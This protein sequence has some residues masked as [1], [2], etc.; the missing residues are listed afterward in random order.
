MAITITQDINNSI[1]NAY[2]NAVILFE[3]DNVLPSVSATVDV[4]GVVL[5]ITPD[6]NG[7]FR[8]NFKEVIKNLI[9]SNN[10]SDA[11]SP[12]IQSGD[13]TTIKYDGNA[14]T[15]L[16][17]NVT[18]IV[19][20]SDNSTETLSKSY[21]FIRAV[22]QH[23]DFY[24]GVIE[25]NKDISLLHPIVDEQ[26]IKHYAR[27]F[28]GYPFDL[29]IF[30]KTPSASLEVLNKTNSIGF[31]FTSPSTNVTRLFF[32]DG[33]T[34]VSIENYVPLL[35]GYN[36]IEITDLDTQSIE[37]QK[38]D[39]GC[40][41]YLKWLNNNGG[42]SYWLFNN[43]HD[44]VR[45]IESGDDVFNDFENLGDNNT[46]YFQLGNNTIDTLDLNYQDA[47]RDDK[48]VLNSLADSP[49]VY[50]FTGKPFSQ[51][52]NDNWLRV[53]LDERNIT[54]RDVRDNIYNIELSIELPM[55]NTMTL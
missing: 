34:D 1:N 8:Y 2:N 31:T 50:L 16:V 15:Y 22:S 25:S 33:R 5:T 39:A 29:S 10:F 46:P 55:R 48:S 49:S 9:N 41:V 30:R 6:T 54:I 43:K 44:R 21:N 4:N 24:R 14:S 53:K 37:L 52:D 35:D 45:G 42:W 20:L 13:E 28:E 18:L 51:V 40:G 32:S 19:T 27:Y 17:A 7:V 3:S 26:P 12:D 36:L 47:T 11:V 23:E 38:T